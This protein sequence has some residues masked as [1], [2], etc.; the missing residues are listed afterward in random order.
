MNSPDNEDDVCPICFDCLNKDNCDQLKKKKKKSDFDEAKNT[1]ITLDCRHKFHYECIVDWFK[2]KRMKHPYSS[3]GKSIRVCPYCREKTGYIELPPNAFPI[4]FI[5]KEYSQIEECINVGDQN[6]ILE[7]CKPY[8]NQ[9]YCLCVLK[10][11]A[12][13]GQQCR[14]YKTNGSNYCAIH[15]KKY[16]LE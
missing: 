1:V 10:S 4:K 5:H 7:I 2:Q 8:F 13:K 3:S 6:K 16:Q 11:G 9:K 15:K 14:K 12:S